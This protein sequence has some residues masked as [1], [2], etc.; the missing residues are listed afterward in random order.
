MKQDI[1]FTCILAVVL[2][3]FFIG[4]S[5]DQ[6]TSVQQEAEKGSGIYRSHDGLQILAYQSGTHDGYFWSLWTSDGLTGSVNYSNGSGGNYS[7]SWNCNGNFTCGKGWSTGSLTRIVGYNCGAYSQSGGGGSFGYYGWTR[8]PLREYYVNEKWPGTRPTGTSMGTINSDG[9]TYNLYRNQRVNAP[10][11]DGTQT[12]WQIFSTRTSQAPTGQNRTI[13]FANHANAWANAGWGLGSDLSPAAILLT[14]AWGQSSGY[15]NA[16]V[17]S[18]GSGGGDGGGGG[19]TG[20]KQVRNRATGLYLDGMGR[21][22]NGAAA[23]QYANTSHVN[24]HWNITSAGS[25]YYYLI[26][27][28]TNM[29]LDGYGRTVNGDACAQY[30]SVTTHVNAQWSI[31]S[32]GSGY[33]YLV[34]R[35]TNMRLD[36]MGRTN[37]GAD[38]GQWANT[39]HQNAQW[40]IVN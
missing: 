30:S 38:A 9:G 39:T 14:E 12:F 18:A 4:C 32:A 40:Q 19:I 25:G 2:T 15:S 36:G 21:T 26:N 3:A 34:N 6:P 17:W 16:T 10:S 35:G 20:L 7:V 33:Y 5:N 24:A 8:N 13:T 22:N 28:G 31:V 37:N 11:I 23:G 1:T 29:K 27:Q